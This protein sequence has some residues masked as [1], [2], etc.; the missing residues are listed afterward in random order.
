MYSIGFQADDENRNVFENEDETNLV[1]SNEK[2]LLLES[3][4]TKARRVSVILC[5]FNWLI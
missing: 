5:K 4:D 2:M 3:L 1:Y